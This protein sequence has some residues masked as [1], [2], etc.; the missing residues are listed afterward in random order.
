MN[1]KSLLA[2]STAAT[3]ALFASACSSDDKPS[4]PSNSDNPGIENPEDPNAGTPNDPTGGDD[5]TV[6]G[7]ST[8]TEPIVVEPFTPKGILI[9]DFEDG[10]GETAQGKVG[11]LTTTS[12]TVALLS[13]KPQSAK[14]ATPL[15]LRAATTPITASR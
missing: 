1:K 4:N 9:D 8:S 14:K 6:G 13:S 11:S 5:P 15:L 3:F 10:D 7:D 12:P 2:L